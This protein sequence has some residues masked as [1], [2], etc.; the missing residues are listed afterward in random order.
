MKN[1]KQVAPFVRSLVWP[2]PTGFLRLVTPHEVRG[3]GE[4]LNRGRLPPDLAAK[5]DQLAKGD[6][7]HRFVEQN[8]RLFVALLLASNEGVF[9]V[10]HGGRQRLLQ[11]LAY[12]RKEEDAIPDYVNGGYGDDGQAVRSV[13]TESSALLQ[14]FK[15][16][17]LRHQAPRL[18]PQQS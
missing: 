17:R 14:R 4:A 10:S 11:A 15:S 8:S 1:R 2:E 16:W 9:A 7:G 18:W 13:A 12:V 5:L 3:L 6:L